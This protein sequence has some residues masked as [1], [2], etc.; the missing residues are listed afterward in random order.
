MTA[1]SKCER[2]RDEELMSEQQDPPVREDDANQAAVETP[3]TTFEES[4]AE[5][6]TGSE[7]AESSAEDLSELLEQAHERIRRDPHRY[8]DHVLGEHEVGGT[9]WLY[10]SSVPFEEIKFPALP[11]KSPAAITETIQ[12]GIFK[13]FTGPIVFELSLKE[14]MESLEYLKKHVPHLL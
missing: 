1:W 9:S 12:H 6:E 7:I 2:G 11:D 10:L 4:A 14:A 5:F 8:V 3:E 13:G